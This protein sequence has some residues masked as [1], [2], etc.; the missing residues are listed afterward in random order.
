MKVTTRDEIVESGSTGLFLVYSSNN[1]MS[2][3]TEEEDRAVREYLDILGIPYDLPNHYGMSIT[4]LLFVGKNRQRFDN[5]RVVIH[6]MKQDMQYLNGLQPW[7]A[8]EDYY[9][10]KGYKRGEILKRWRS[11]Q[12]TND[13]LSANEA[14]DGIDELK[15]WN[16]PQTWPEHTWKMVNVAENFKMVGVSGPLKPFVAINWGQKM[17]PISSRKEEQ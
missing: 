1:N 15:N 17:L 3:H 12:M 14:I 9:F 5:M 6:S 16:E 4:G 13:S 2:Y 7:S 10:P 8:H 11:S